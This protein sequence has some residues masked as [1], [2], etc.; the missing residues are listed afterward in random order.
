MMRTSPINIIGF[1]RLISFFEKSCEC[2]RLHRFASCND[3]DQHHHDGDNQQSMN[4]SAHS[5]AAQQSKQPQN[6]KNQTDGPKHIRL[7][8][9]EQCRLRLELN[10]ETKLIVLSCPLSFVSDYRSYSNPTV[11]TVKLLLRSPLPGI[12]FCLQQTTFLLLDRFQGL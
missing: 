7:L 10:M 3:S 12:S 2:K 9:G 11:A 6:Q 4:Y 8:S 1:M 5:V